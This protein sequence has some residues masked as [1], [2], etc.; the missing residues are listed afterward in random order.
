MIFAFLPRAI[1]FNPA[2]FRFIRFLD[3][4]FPN[5][6]LINTCFKK[7]EGNDEQQLSIK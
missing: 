4:S 6:L 1:N 3:E 7:K 2:I 5:L